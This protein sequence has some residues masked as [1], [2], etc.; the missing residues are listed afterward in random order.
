MLDA[1]AQLTAG[2]Q[3]PDPVVMRIHD[4]STSTDSG[5]FESPRTRIEDWPH[6][7]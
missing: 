3:R 2:T 5:V 1:L 4:E 6:S 7:S